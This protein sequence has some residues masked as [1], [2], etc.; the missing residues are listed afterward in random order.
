[1]FDVGGEMEPLPGMVVVIDPE[2]PGRLT[3]STS[4][5]DC[6]VAGIISGAGGVATGMTM[7]H[8]GTIADGEHP[9]ALSGRVF[10]LV[11]ATECAVAPGDMLTTSNTPGH[12]MKATDRERAHGSVIGKAMTPLA[13]GERGLVLVLVNLQ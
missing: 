7:G 5:Y 13:L 10:C 11:D 12:A 9:V 4:A 3:P 2:H 1:M 8:D 6:K